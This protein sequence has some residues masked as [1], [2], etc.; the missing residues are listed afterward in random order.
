MPISRAAFLQ[1]VAAV[2]A[3]GLATVQTPLELTEAKDC[4]DELSRADLPLPLVIVATQ[5]QRVTLDD[6][7]AWIATTQPYLEALLAM[8]GALFFRSFPTPLAVDFG[9]FVDSFAC[10]KDLPYEERLAIN[11]RHRATST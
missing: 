6:T 9:R 4:G 8:T 5:P 2:E 7:T 11:G 1:A 10:W 3:S